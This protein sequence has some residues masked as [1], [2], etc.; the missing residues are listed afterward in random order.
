LIHF[1]Q[2]KDFSLGEI[3]VALV[4]DSADFTINQ[5]WLKQEYDYDRM[6]GSIP[7]FRWVLQPICART[8]QLVITAGTSESEVLKQ[9]NFVFGHL[10][11]LKNR[12]VLIASIVNKN[13]GAIWE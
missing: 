2:E 6:R 1:S 11:Q 9:A 12:T 7:Y 3:F 5:Q 8:R 4:F 10:D 13:T